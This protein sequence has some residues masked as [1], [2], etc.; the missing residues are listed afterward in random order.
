MRVSCYTNLPDAE[1]FLNGASLG[2]KASVPGSGR[3]TWEVPFEPG[4]LSVCSG[5]LEDRLSARF[6]AETLRCVLIRDMHG[7]DEAE[8]LQAE[9]FLEDRDGRPALDE[10]IR[11]QVVGDLELLG[12]ENGIPDDLTPYS[13]PC[14]STLNSR[15]IIYLRKT[16]GSSVERSS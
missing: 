4:T 5:A 16:G 8:V 2:R 11:C 3:I 13:A 12:I 1:L 15:M 10:V 6:P 7:D 14:R 9:V